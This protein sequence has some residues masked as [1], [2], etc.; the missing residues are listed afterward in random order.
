MSDSIIIRKANESDLEEI[1]SII[2]SPVA[3]NGTAMELRDA[4]TVY[5]SILDDSN[6]FQIVASSEK[7][8]V[9]IITLIIIMQMTH[10]GSTTAYITD[11][12]ISEQISSDSEKKAITVDLLHYVTELAQEYG[13]YKT[14]FHNDYHQSLIESS[15]NE[16]GIKKG[17]PSFELPS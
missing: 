4:N 13:C 16:L 15:G 8:I 2:N 7:G 3:D 10:E 11:L 17:T 1:L 6:Y 9:A 14:I 12:V 5:Q